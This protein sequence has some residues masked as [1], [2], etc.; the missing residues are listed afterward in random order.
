MHAMVLLADDHTLLA[1]AS[2]A[3]LAPPLAVPCALGALVVLLVATIGLFSRASF[4][5]RR[6]AVDD[7]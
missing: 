3:L 5:L 6:S 2:T 7:A 1:L 4:D